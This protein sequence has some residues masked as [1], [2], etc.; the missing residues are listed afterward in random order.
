MAYGSAST[1]GNYG[2]GSGSMSINQPSAQFTYAYGLPQG[3]QQP[4]ANSSMG[5]MVSFRGSQVPYEIARRNGYT[6]PAP[7]APATSSGYNSSG[8]TTASYGPS[9]S[10]MNFLNSVVQGQT[11]PYDQATQ[12]NM[13]AKQSDM[14]AAG[15]RALNGR[16]SAQAMSGGANPSDPSFQS[17]QRNAM[18]NRQGQNAA[19][20]QSIGQEA[21]RSNFGARLQAAGS[22]STFELAQ[23]ERARAAQTA[24]QSGAFNTTTQPGSGGSRVS[25]YGTAAQGYG[26]YGGVGQPYVPPKMPA[27]GGNALGYHY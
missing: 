14:N 25:G 20:A 3:G 18:A 21:N 22:M 17:A 1:Y 16:M 8:S 12:D 4:P 5:G 26:N 19:A 6:G 2:P 7:A 15:E 13:L 10:A 23:Q 27:Q 24:L 9:S 11:L